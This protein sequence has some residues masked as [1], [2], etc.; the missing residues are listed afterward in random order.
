ME[1]IKLTTYLILNKIRE[2]NFMFKKNKKKNLAIL[3]ASIMCMSAIG[4]SN[5]SAM[6]NAA[7]DNLNRYVIIQENDPTIYGETEI[8]HLEN[9]NKEN[10]PINN[11]AS[12]EATFSFFD[13]LYAIMDNYSKTY[14]K[15]VQSQFANDLKDGNTGRL[16][17]A[18]RRNEIRKK[19]IEVLKEM[20]RILSLY[21]ICQGRLEYINKIFEQI[22]SAKGEIITDESTI[23]DIKGIGAPI[24]Y[25]RLKTKYKDGN[26]MR[27]KIKAAIDDLFL[28]INK[29]A[30]DSAYVVNDQNAR[31]HTNLNMIRIKTILLD[32][33]MYISGQNIKFLL[34]NAIASKFNKN[35]EK[36][37]KEIDLSESQTTQLPSLLKGE[38]KSFVDDMKKDYGEVDSTEFIV[39]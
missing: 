21:Y 38:I 19:Y 37:L 3:I 9:W 16:L 12:Y 36:I 5:V 17:D 30:D 1:K 35:M 32:R 11:F 29:Q 26:E 24:S 18:N 25:I 28:L 13:S 23:G 15:R 34:R 2:E 33:N 39:D 7:L 22:Y 27:L 20:T 8:K 6:N 31:N 10:I 14:A 4:F